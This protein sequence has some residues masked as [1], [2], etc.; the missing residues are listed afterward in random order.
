MGKRFK[1]NH[2]VVRRTIPTTHRLISTLF[3]KTIVSRF[4]FHVKNDKLANQ[5]HLNTIFRKDRLVQRESMYFD[6]LVVFKL[7]SK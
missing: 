3:L 2:M 6:I 4:D 1:S 7:S 5:G